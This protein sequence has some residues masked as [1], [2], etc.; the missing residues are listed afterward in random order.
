[1]P[2]TTRAD[3]IIKVPDVRCF[4]TIIYSARLSFGRIRYEN[5]FDLPVTGCNTYLVI[6]RKCFV[7]R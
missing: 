7:L 3:V 2:K 4:F 1:M 6:A 5:D